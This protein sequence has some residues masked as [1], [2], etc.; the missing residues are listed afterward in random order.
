MEAADSSRML[1]PM[2]IFQNYMASHTKKK[3]NIICSHHQED[4]SAGGKDLLYVAKG[5]DD[6]GLLNLRTVSTP[7]HSKT[8]TKFLSPCC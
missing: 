8:S 6:L 1:A 4:L 2:C 5:T 3:K 7:L